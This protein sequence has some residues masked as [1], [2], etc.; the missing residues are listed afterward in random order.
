MVCWCLPQALPWQVRHEPS[1]IPFLPPSTNSNSCQLRHETARQCEGRRHL[2]FTWCRR[3]SQYG[4]P[5]VLKAV[6]RVGMMQLN[7]KGD[8]TMLIEGGL[9]RSSLVFAGLFSVSSGWK[10]RLYKVLTYSNKKICFTGSLLAGFSTPGWWSGSQGEGE[11]VNPLC[12][13]HCWD[14]QSMWVKQYFCICY[15]F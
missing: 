9:N 7:L 6:W 8:D 2:P 12:R 10:Q 4:V 11:A 14:A 15:Q 13:L 5:H 1:L 3:T